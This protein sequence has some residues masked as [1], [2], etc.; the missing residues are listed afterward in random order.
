M[1]FSTSDSYN[2]EEDGFEK[3]RK[4]SWENINK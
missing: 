1:V 3:D 2:N 4:G